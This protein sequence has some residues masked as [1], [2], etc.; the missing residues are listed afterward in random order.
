ML[1]LISVGNLSR[2]TFQAMAETLGGSTRFQNFEKKL[3]S[4]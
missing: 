4:T 1:K 2:I 3:F